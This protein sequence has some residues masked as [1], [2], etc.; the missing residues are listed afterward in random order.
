MENAASAAKYAM[1]N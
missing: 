1:P